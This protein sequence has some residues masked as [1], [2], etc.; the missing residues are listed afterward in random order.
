MIASQGEV[1]KKWSSPPGPFDCRRKFFPASHPAGDGVNWANSSLLNFENLREELD[2]IHFVASAI[3][4]QL[5]GPLSLSRGN[6]P[7]DGT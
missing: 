3:S 2:L 6:G 5:D 1:K 7:L 4:P